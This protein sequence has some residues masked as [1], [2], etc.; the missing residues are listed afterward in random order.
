VGSR[1]GFA[2]KLVGVALVLN[3]AG[4]L[5]FLAG[6]RRRRAASQP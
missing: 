5:L 6:T 3:L 4:V 1:L 2:A